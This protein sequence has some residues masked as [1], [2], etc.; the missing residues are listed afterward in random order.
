MGTL[1]AANVN[2][3]GNLKTPSRPMFNVAG[4]TTNI[5]WTSD[6]ILY[7]MDANVD[8]T[9]SWNKTTGKYVI[10]EAGHYFMF[11]HGT[12]NDGDSHFLEIWKGNS[13]RLYSTRALHYGVAFQ[14]TQISFIANCAINDEIT[15]RRRASGYDFY[16]ISV[17]LYLI[18]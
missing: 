3:T 13:S 12:T 4:Q 17:G 9:S 5:E 11:F 8:T 1:N 7:N 2:L 15:W 16:S 10:P 6:T 14:G 18:G